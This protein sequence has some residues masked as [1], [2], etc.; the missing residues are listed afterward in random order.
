MVEWALLAVSVVLI[1]ACGV[2]VAGEFSLLAADRATVERQADAGD[3]RSRGVLA[4]FRTLSTQLSGVQIGITLTNLVI[5]LLS[6]PAIAKLLHSPLQAVGVRGAAVD[7]VAVVVALVVSTLATTVFGELLPKN[8]AI[9]DP[10]G[11]AKAVQAPV[12]GFTRLMRVPIRALNGAAA[13]ILRPFGVELQEEL[14]SARSAE[15]L[16]S[17]VRHSASEGTLPA[18]TATLLVRTLSFGDKT[19]GDV[20]TPRP[21]VVAVAEKDTVAEFLT[22]VGQSGQSRMPVTGPDGLDDVVGA[23]E[24]D[25]AVAVSRL[26]RD[27]T[28][29]RAVMSPPVEIPEQLPLDD[30]L[31]TLQSARC[32]LAVV[33][34]EYGGTAGL[35]TGEDLLEELIGE[36]DDEHDR[37]V[38]AVRR[39]GEGWDLS[40]RLRPDEISA[41][42][43]LRLPEGPYETIAGLVLRA[44]GRIPSEGDQAV[45][46]GVRLTVTRMDGLRIDRLLAGVTDD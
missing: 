30:V 9:A 17:L 33:I 37:P 14:A 12:R 19:A 24:L 26:M 3:R 31:H 34:D 20:L 23:I 4:A 7:A 11:V 29:V 27:Q 35:V 36:V 46:N 25:A 6:E 10:V 16:M 22:L 5:G 40:G 15:E 39:S 13:A 45:V 8:L 41:L 2:F 18:R 42:T 32:Q 43:G 28:P 21:Q 38:P 1:A 44:L